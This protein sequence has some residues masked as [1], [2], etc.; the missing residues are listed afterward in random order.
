MFHNLGNFG[1]SSTKTPNIIPIIDDFKPDLIM[2]AELNSSLAAD[3]FLKNG[4]N[5]NTVGLTYTRPIT[6]TENT[7]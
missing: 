3:N 7:S 6:Y 1:A 5:K 4:L 2:A